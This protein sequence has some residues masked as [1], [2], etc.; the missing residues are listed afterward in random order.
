MVSV[1]TLSDGEDNKPLMV[2]V[3][4][5]GE[6]VVGWSDKSRGKI[7]ETTLALGGL[8]KCLPQPV[9]VA[10]QTPLSTAPN[11]RNRALATDHDGDD[12]RHVLHAVLIPRDTPQRYMEDAPSQVL[13]V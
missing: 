5:V 3:L 8:S 2:V 4:C 12:P 7:A 10:R 6:R 11:T 9:H 13:H 1:G